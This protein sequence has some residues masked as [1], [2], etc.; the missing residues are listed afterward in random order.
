[1]TNSEDLGYL[2]ATVDQNTQQITALTEMFSAHAEKEEK[3][4]DEIM[5]HIQGL[6]DELNM[7]KAVIRV[8]KVVGATALLILTLKLGSI[9]S[10]WKDM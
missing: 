3:R 2:K 4:T 10:L 6:K 1:M 5:E 9:E 8:V 7:Y